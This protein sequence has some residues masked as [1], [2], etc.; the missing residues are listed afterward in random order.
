MPRKK[1]SKI[2]RLARD[3][4][5]SGHFSY[6]KT[7][8]RLENVY[9]RSKSRDVEKYCAGYVICQ[10]NKDGRTKR[11]STPTPLGISIRRC[12][13]MVTDFITHLPRSKSGFSCITT[14]AEGLKEKYISL[15]ASDWIQQLRLQII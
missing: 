15:P 8:S 2:F 4:R 10:Q 7:M 9:W 12:G 11:I 5:T 3:A 13:S 1:F 6:F 14:Y